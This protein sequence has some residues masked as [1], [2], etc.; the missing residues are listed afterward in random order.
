MGE[1]FFAYVSPTAPHK[2]YIPARRDAHTFDGLEAPRSPSFNEEDVSD[3][4]P[5]IQLLP[6]L[7]ADEIVQLDDRHEA[8]AE[9]LQALDDLVEGVVNKLE[10]EGAL[11]NTYVVFTSDNGWHHGEHRIPREKTQPYEE[12][13]RVPLLIRGPGVQAGSATSKLT[14]NT[15]YLPTFTDLA[16]IETPEYVD[17]RSLRPVME[18]SATA[19][20]SAFLMERRKGDAPSQSYYGIRASGLRKYLEYEGGFR[21]YYDLHTDPYELANSY[22]AS[23]PPAD[24]AARLQALKSCAGATCRAAEDGP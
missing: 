6:R 22:D 18:G 19:W 13:S 15:D 17:G 16:G 8:R 1:P 9:T 14:L 24:L 11:E 5:W 12:S 2:P 10:A 23:A 4:P 20:R 21:E 7:S 3:K